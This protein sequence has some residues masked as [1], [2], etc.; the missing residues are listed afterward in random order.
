MAGTEPIVRVLICMRGCV[1]LCVAVCMPIAVSRHELDPDVEALKQSMSVFTGSSRGSLRARGSPSVRA[2]TAT[3]ADA[4]NSPPPHQLEAGS[5][6]GGSGRMT[7]L[8]QRR[9]SSSGAEGSPA[10]G[11]RAQQPASEQRPGSPATTTT[12]S[13]GG[14][15][16]GESGRAEEAVAGTAISPTSTATHSGPLHWL[17]GTR[18][19]SRARDGD[20]SAL[21]GTAVDTPSSVAAT[22]LPAA[23]S[24]HIVGSRDH[25]GSGATSAAATMR[26]KSSNLA[27]GGSGILPLSLSEGQVPR[28]R[29]ELEGQ[30]ESKSPRMGVVASAVGFFLKLKRFSSSVRGRIR[31][32]RW[33]K[34]E[35][36]RPGV[37][38][39]PP[40]LSPRPTM[41]P[42]LTA[43]QEEELA[44]LE[45]MVAHVRRVV[46][47]DDHQRGTMNTQTPVRAQAVTLYVCL[48]LL[49]VGHSLRLVR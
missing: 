47:S 11:G 42:P 32:R 1:W 45:D 7:L 24:P 10:D 43:V 44:E 16:G 18:R 20:N 22:V 33:Q 29:G 41:P 31:R 39:G 19:R 6:T 4:A 21:S 37:L 13:P 40:I 3:A 8:A 34:H 49:W 28:T 12:S 14:G 23:A 9:G 38:G 48:R 26:S 30:S 25:S 46:R 15:S 17:N 36:G 5:S 2:V 35:E 27:R